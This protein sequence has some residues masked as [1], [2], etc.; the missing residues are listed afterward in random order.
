MAITSLSLQPEPFLGLN[1]RRPPLGSKIIVH[2][3]THPSAIGAREK[4]LYHQGKIFHFHPLHLT[5]FNMQ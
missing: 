3:T 2:D 1:A 5:L 4:K